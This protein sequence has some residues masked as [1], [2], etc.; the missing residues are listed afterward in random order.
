MQG[1]ASLV[2]SCLHDHT[3]I[4]M[5]YR[6]CLQNLLDA[7]GEQIGKAF[8][9]F[10]RSQLSRGPLKSTD[11][12]QSVEVKI[13][14]SRLLQAP[15]KFFLVDFGLKSVIEGQIYDLVMVEVR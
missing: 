13:V 3:Q 8:C 1:S 6:S 15:Y 9:E 14:K 4:K 11:V 2:T 10:F 5:I 7:F 12:F